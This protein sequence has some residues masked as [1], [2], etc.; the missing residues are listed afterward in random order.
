MGRWTKKVGFRPEGAFPGQ[1]HDGH[2]PLRPSLLARHLHP[3]WGIGGTE[4]VG[5][6]V[7]VPG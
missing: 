1:D 2:G 7:S 5:K 6:E 3:Y 4:A